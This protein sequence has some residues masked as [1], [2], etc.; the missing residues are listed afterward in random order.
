[1][2]S[3]INNNNIGCIWGVI[4]LFIIPV[5]GVFGIKFLEEEM[6]RGVIF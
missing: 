4:S 6:N 2:S 3:D 5:V 1:M